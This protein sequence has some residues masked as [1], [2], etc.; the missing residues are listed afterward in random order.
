MNGVTLRLLLLPAVTGSGRE[1]EIRRKSAWYRRSDGRID[2]TEQV[3]LPVGR[4][5]GSTGAEPK[6]IIKRKNA[7]N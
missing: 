3:C 1:A 2:I 7:Q 5:W 4:E 6:P